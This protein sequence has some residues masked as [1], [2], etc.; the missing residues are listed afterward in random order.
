MEYIS[1]FINICRTNYIKVVNLHEFYANFDCG[2]QVEINEN[3]VLVLQ[4]KVAILQMTYS[5]TFS[6][7]N[8]DVLWLISD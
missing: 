1:N 7:I 4:Q 6:H 2:L 3:M 8:I 5:N